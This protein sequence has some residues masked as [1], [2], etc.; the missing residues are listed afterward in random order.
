MKIILFISDMEG[1]FTLENITNDIAKE[2]AYTLFTK[3]LVKI[4]NDNKADQIIF[5]LATSYNDPS[6]VQKS[7]NNVKEPFAKN[8]VVIGK[9]FLERMY[10][11]DG[12]YF[13]C[14]KNEDSFKLNKVTKYINE[15]KEQGHEIVWFGFADDSL[16]I[17]AADFFKEMIPTEIPYDVFVPGKGASN[18]AEHLYVSDQEGILGLN[19]CILSSVGDYSLR[20]EV[21]A[22]YP[23]IKEE[24][25][26]EDKKDNEDKQNKSS[27]MKKLMMNFGF[28]NKK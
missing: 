16:G 14:D 22:E 28:N 6:Y 11:Q 25:V 19:D 23:V 9:C 24:P 21:E 3:L 17:V 4:K 2:K 8:N 5:S 10:Y 27:F 20:D 12:K 26:L 15:L 7:L 18:A 13:Q 1:T